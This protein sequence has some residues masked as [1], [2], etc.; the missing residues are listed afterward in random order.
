MFKAVVYRALSIILGL[1]AII[2]LIWLWMHGQRELSFIP[3]LLVILA[4]LF[5]QLYKK[6]K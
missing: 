6:I 5:L 3:L 4:S 2:I 1:V